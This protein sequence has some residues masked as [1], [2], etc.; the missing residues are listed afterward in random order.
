[1][2]ETAPYLGNHTF[3]IFGRLKQGSFLE[4][5]TPKQDIGGWYRNE[6]RWDLVI[7]M[8]PQQK[9]AMAYE[10]KAAGIIDSERAI[11]IFG[12]E[13]PPGMVERVKREKLEEAHMQAQLQGGSPPGG[14]AGA[15]GGGGGGMPGGQP[16]ALLPQIA[17]PPGMGA[18]RQMAM[19]AQAGA[20]G[21]QQGVTLEAVRRALEPVLSKL[22]GTVAVVGDLA[23]QGVGQHIEALISE[24]KDYPVVNP[25][26]QAL[27]KQAKVKAM[28]EARWPQD[29]VRIA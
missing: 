22:K 25:L 2:Q 20:A 16:Q 23:T 28:D 8:N 11:E 14:E 15:P 1:M 5:F 26:L 3:E 19:Q 17:R 24:Y 7:G 13:D 29:A 21:G 6:V 4:Q 18:D 27:D 10:A 12:E 9:T